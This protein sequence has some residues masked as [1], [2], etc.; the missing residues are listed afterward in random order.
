VTAT[1]GVA[2]EQLASTDAFVVID[3]PGAPSAGVVRR[4]RKILQAGA[5]DLARSVTY[6]FGAF[7]IERGGA[8]AGINAE[9]DQVD[10]AVQAFVAELAPVAAERG[11][12]LEAGKGVEPEQLAEL[13]DAGGA[14]PLAGSADL[15]ATGVVAAT[16]WALG[17][18]LDGRSVAI[19]GIDQAPP[20][21]RRALT[22]AGATVVDVWGVNEK[23][24]LIWG[25]DVDA[26]LAGSRAGVLTHQG[27]G[28][29]SARAIVPWGPIPVTTKA[30]VQLRRAG[31]VVVPDFVST[32]G[33]WLGG[34]SSDEG[35]GVT[36]RIAAVLDE[37]AS[38]PDGV[39]LG[40]CHLAEA[41]IETWQ[42]R[43][44]FGR[45]LAA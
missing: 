31:K 25:A 41:F 26:V 28:S 27:T 22:E 17:G 36:A 35:A 40:A 7:G 34:F 15:L 38:H 10:G 45:P 32:A 44:P 21:L 5:T 24:W 12:Q 18:D 42:E 37:A 19:E 6:T 2:V 3:F 1:S 43:K 13:R 39:L 4:A 11:L 23:P 9:G 20:A 30:F 8:S 29:V 14:G 33:F 16:S